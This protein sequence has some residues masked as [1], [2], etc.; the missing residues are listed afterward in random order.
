MWQFHHYLC[1][2][3]WSEQCGS[4]NTTCA[5][6]FGVNSVAVSLLSVRLSV[7]TVAVSPLSVQLSVNSVAVL[8]EKG[9]CT[10]E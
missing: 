2:C 8:P 7:N 3:L 4:F 1:G 9:V 6:I 10:Y 5:A